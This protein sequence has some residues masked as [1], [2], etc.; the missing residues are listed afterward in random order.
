MVMRAKAGVN[1]G[2]VATL[3]S[4]AGK[5]NRKTVR[6]AKQ[7]AKDAPPPML[8]PGLKA[9]PAPSSDRF[10]LRPLPWLP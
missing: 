8:P 6:A 2:R 4:Y 7:G 1:A 3:R 9:P 10:H 5:R